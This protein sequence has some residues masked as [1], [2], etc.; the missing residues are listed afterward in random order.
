M[1]SSWWF[2][3]RRR[4]PSSYNPPTTSG[5]RSS[6]LGD[7]PLSYFLPCRGFRCRRCRGFHCRRSPT[8]HYRHSQTFR[9]RRCRGFHCRRSPTYHYR[10][11]QT[12][13]SPPNRASCCRRSLRWTCLRCRAFRC[14]RCQAFRC[15]RYPWRWSRMLNSRLRERQKARA[16]EWIAE[17]NSGRV[18]G[19]SCGAS[20]GQSRARSGQA[21]GGIFGPQLAGVPKP[22][23]T[24]FPG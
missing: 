7:C 14:L 6:S 18:G 4:F 22:V 12:S 9:C 23:H 3:L 20:F 8:Y 16:T 5:P 24:A 21:V 19:K 1:C 11:S 15:L 2:P 10:H 13:H 17:R